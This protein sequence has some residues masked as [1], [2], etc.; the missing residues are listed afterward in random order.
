[1]AEYRRDDILARL[2]QFSLGSVNVSGHPIEGIRNP[3]RVA[4]RLHTERRRV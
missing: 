4:L 1:M 2:Q 3:S